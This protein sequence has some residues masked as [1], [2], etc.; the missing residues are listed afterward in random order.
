MFRTIK[1]DFVIL[2]ALT[3]GIGRQRGAMIFFRLSPEIITKRP[4]LP[5]VLNAI[6][7]I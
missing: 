2:D 4:I 5:N 7:T 1:T 3:L 6:T